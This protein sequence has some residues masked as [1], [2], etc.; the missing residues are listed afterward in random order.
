MHQQ[1]FPKVLR[2]VQTRNCS[3]Q[4][5]LSK[6][7]GGVAAK[8]TVASPTHLIV[9]AS[10]IRWNSSIPRSDATYKGSRIDFRPKRIILLRHGESDGN[11]DEAAYV[12]TADWCINLTA[13]GKQQ[14]QDAGKRIRDVVGED[15]KLVF[16]FS[17]YERTRQTLDTITNYVQEESI[18][19]IREEPRISEQQF[20]NFQNVQEVIN[21]KSER[22]RFGRFYYRFPSGEAG[23]DVY[24]RVSSFISTLVRDCHQYKHNN[25]DLENM[26]VVIITHGLTLRLFLM[27]W[28]QFSVKEFEQSENPGNAELTILNK[29]TSS[30]GQHKWY[31]LEQDARKAL[32]LPDSC[33]IPKNVLLHSLSDRYEEDEEAL[34]IT[35]SGDKWHF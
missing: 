16:Y 27:R 8:S 34:R 31:E 14:A 6:I 10:T 17:P 29:K 32:N 22:H 13:K 4:L 30:D 33:G 25:Y 9:R 7:T 3:P 20:G 5:C 35:G 23:L 28:F 2:T 19:S 18:I 1:F 24:S 21:A 11:I 12:D 15:G 26:N